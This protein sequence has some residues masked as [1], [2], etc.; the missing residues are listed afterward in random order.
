MPGDETGLMRVAAKAIPQNVLAPP[1]KS[2]IFLILTV[3]EGDEAADAVR[4][5]LGDVAALVRS[6]GFRIPEAQLSCVVGIGS[7]VWDRLYADAPRPAHLHPFKPLT[8]AVHEAPSTPG[9]LLFHIRST[10][11]DTCFELTR[12][13]MARLGGVADAVEE[14]QG[15]RYYDER[16][17]LGFVDG[18]ENPGG[19]VAE[20][21]VFVGD[22]DHEFAG[23]S[24]VIVQK[25]LHDLDAWG[26]LTVEQQ[27]LVI[28]RTKSD[29]IELPDDVKPTNSHVAA[30]TIVDA[31]G[32]ERRIVRENM[33]FGSAGAGEFG[34]FFCGYAADPSITELMLHRMFIGEPEGNY[35]RILDFSTARSGC[36]FFVPTASFLEDQAD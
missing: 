17:L 19:T 34:T 22:E 28:G 3:R 20:S 18:T 13:L 4:G 30:N 5:V 6:V 36:N 15:F 23:S 21:T 27:Q 24:Y 35:D 26:S 25:Y 33:P 31:D 7:D 11:H 1:A 10:R 29:D 12:Q 14:I 9:D 16:D 8:G 2:A 32:N